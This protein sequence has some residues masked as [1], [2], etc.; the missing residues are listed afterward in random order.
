ML[1]RWRIIGWNGIKHCKSHYVWGKIVNYQ[2]VTAT[3]ARFTIPVWHFWKE[4]GVTRAVYRFE[5]R[6][7]LV[8]LGSIPLTSRTK[9]LKSWYSQISC[10]MFSI[11]GNQRTVWKTSRQVRLLGLWARHLPECHYLEW[12]DWTGGSLTRIPKMTLV[13]E[14]T[15]HINEQEPRAWTGRPFSFFFLEI[16]FF[17]S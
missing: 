1:K 4:P 8:D 6:L 11:A 17:C 12:L 10:L 15:W 16:R 3:R 7:Y 14:I 9:D 2:T 13:D 5:L